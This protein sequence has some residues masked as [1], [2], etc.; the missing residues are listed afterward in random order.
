MKLNF[1]HIID[2]N[3]TSCKRWDLI[4][5]Q[6]PLLIPMGIADMDFPAPLEVAQAI[7]ERLCHP[8]FGYTYPSE[9]LLDTIV[10]Y[11]DFLYQWKIKK[12]W[13]V[14][15]PDATT[16]LYFL[17]NGIS[18]AKKKIILQPPVFGSFF[19][20]IA[21]A[22]HSIIT[23]PL[24]FD[25]DSYFID[26]NHLSQLLKTDSH[27]RALLFCNPQNPI[28]RVWSKNELIQL[29]TICLENNCLIISD[30][31]HSDLIHQGHQHIPIASLNKEFEQNSITVISPG[32][33]FN[34]AGLKISALIIPNDQIR[35]HIN[36]VTH[37]MNPNILAM[38]AYEA[39]LT[40][41]LSYY[42]R[43][44]SQYLTD[45]F[46]FVEDFINTRIPKLKLIKAQ[47][48]FLAWINMGNLQLSPK[49]LDDF[50][51]NKAKLCITPGYTFGE[52]G[53]GFGRFNIGMPRSELKKAFIQ[54]E[55]AINSL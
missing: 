33:G 41:G 15:Y 21:R 46:L 14:L 35:D 40:A 29:G 22:N 8:C 18:T 45:N 3:N 39:A 16:S 26:F 4:K 50:L 11:M 37:G 52:G 49:E 31:L 2:R 13:I 1:D 5:K 36:I 43:E 9:S 34:I 54:L 51:I 20:D 24:L 47:A 23:N 6:D 17:F 12:E 7:Q 55:K 25:S 38:T 42:T 48:T 30:E 44:L 10:Y 32:K 27:I 19:G 53:E 28:G